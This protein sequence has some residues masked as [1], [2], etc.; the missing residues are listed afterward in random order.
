MKFSHTL[1]TSASPEKIWAIWTD[2]EHWSAWDTELSDARLE[3]AFV[4]GSVGKLTPKAGRVSPFIISQ[5]NAGNSY[6]FTLK[7]P[8]CKLNVYRHLY[9]QSDGT[10]FTHEVSFQ[11]LLAFL[12][13]LLLGRR[14]RIVL[15]SVM[16]N[17]KRIAQA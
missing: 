10:Y 9:S 6:T 17:I 16:E 13:G 8:L 4:L 1:K 3:G 12:F 14:F 2:V 15:P 7:L 5:L 11:G